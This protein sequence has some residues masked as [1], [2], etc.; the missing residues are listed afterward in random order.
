MKVFSSS[1][2]S[3][4]VLLASFQNSLVLLDYQINRSFYE[5]RCVNKDKP[6]MCCHGKCQIKEK[7]ETSKN[8]PETEAVKINY[9]FNFLPKKHVDLPKPPVITVEKPKYSFLEENLSSGY[10]KILPHPPENLV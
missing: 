5:E 9:E 7:E 2:L 4:I 8:A 3:L 6:E 10:F 1:I